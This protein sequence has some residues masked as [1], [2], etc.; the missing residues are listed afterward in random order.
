V[1]EVYMDGKYVGKT[2]LEELKVKSGTHEMKFVKSGKEFTKSMKF[3]AGKN[4]SQMIRI[5]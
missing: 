4:P 5:P 3:D 1:A 2:N